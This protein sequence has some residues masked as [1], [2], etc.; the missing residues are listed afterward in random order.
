MKKHSIV[1]SQD[2]AILIRDLLFKSA[3]NLYWK[4]ANQKNYT[5]TTEE[6]QKH[7]II[8]ELT[9]RIYWRGE[10]AENF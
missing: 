3:G 5:P 1:I 8:E 10:R 2:L 6:Q 4:L 9:K 7:L